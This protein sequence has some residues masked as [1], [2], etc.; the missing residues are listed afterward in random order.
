MVPLLIT[1]LKPAA[2]TRGAEGAGLSSVMRREGSI[3]AAIVGFLSV[4]FW[5]STGTASTTIRIGEATCPQER[6]TAPELNG[7]IPPFNPLVGRPERT[8]AGSR[9]TFGRK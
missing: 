4:V 9:T 5:R 7:S 1:E 6:R 2:A 8:V 3:D